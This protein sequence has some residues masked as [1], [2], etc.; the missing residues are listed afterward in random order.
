MIRKILEFIQ[1]TRALDFS[2]MLIRELKLDINFTMVHGDDHKLVFVVLFLY[3]QINL[4]S[5]LISWL[6]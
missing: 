3:R 1:I 2:L 5:S 6:S 4:F